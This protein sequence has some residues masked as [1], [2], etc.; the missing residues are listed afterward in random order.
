MKECEQGEPG[1]FIVR[2]GNIMT[3]YV[4][5]PEQTA[6]ALHRVEAFKGDPLSQETWCAE[7][8][9]RHFVVASS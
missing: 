6:K 3:G 4:N 2:G 5:Q 9:N 8:V 7:P 1:Y